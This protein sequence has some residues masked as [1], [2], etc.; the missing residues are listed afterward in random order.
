MTHFEGHPLTGHEALIFDLDDTLYPFGNFLSEEKFWE[1][2]YGYVARANNMTE[3]EVKTRC[4]E[5]LATG[6]MDLIP[7]WKDKHVFDIA[8]FTACIDSQD[9]S[10]MGPCDET[11]DLL[12]NWQGQVVVFTN[13][14]RSHAE[15]VLEKIGLTPHVA[16]I[17]DYTTRNLRAKPDPVIYTELLERLALDPK[18]CVMFEDR[19]NNLEPAHAL[20]M[21]TVMVHPEPHDLP[22][23]DYW[24]PDLLTWVRGVRQQ[25]E[26]TSAVA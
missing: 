8:D 11:R 1:I 13:A 18:Q 22:Y 12:A 24:Y 26:K 7:A 5:M 2:F 3:A 14:H 10:H 21:G 4:E 20:G 6:M 25:L 9:I 23:V 16:H 19:A 17:C 15:R